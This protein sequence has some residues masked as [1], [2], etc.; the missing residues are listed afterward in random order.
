MSDAQRQAQTVQRI[1]ECQRRL[2]AYILT[3]LPGTQQADDVLQETNLVLWAK[4]TLLTPQHL[5]A[6]DRYLDEVLRCSSQH[7]PSHRGDWLTSTSTG[8]D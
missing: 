4:G 5:Q 6:Q 7:S 8:T 1:T 2:Y 3:L